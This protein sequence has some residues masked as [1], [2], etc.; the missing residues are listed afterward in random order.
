MTINVTVVSATASHHHHLAVH[1]DVYHNQVNI[2]IQMD[3]YKNAQPI[4]LLLSHTHQLHAVSKLSATSP[5][6][7]ISLT[8]QRQYN[9]HIT[10]GLPWCQTELSSLPV[11]YFQTLL[12]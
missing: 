8:L 12:G 10:T 9:A 4:L 1:S 3:I 6:R 5:C 2:Q 7:R 11:S